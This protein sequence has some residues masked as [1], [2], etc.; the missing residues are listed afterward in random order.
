MSLEFP[1]EPPNGLGQ[2]AIVRCCCKAS[3]F[4]RRPVTCLRVMLGEGVLEDLPL[5]VWALTG[6]LL[7]CEF[8]I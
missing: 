6:M 2:G 7:K 3:G 1:S 4:F 5:H 8:S